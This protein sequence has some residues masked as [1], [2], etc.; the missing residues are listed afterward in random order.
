MQVLCGWVPN[1]SGCACSQARLRARI[2]SWE[3]R[4]AGSSEF[5]FRLRT[6]GGLNLVDALVDG[7]VACTIEVIDDAGM[8]RILV[9]EGDDRASNE[10]DMAWRE[11]RA[12]MDGAM[13]TVFQ[14][15][16]VDRLV[17]TGSGSEDTEALLRKFI[18]TME[19]DA[20]F[21]ARVINGR[22]SLTDHSQSP[23]YI[24]KS[25][26]M[27]NKLYFDAFRD[28]YQ[29]RVGGGRLERLC[30]EMERRVEKNE[31]A[32]EYIDQRYHRRHE[33]WALWISITAAFLSAAAL[34][35][36]V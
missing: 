6:V 27:A 15:T 1:L 24:T 13:F 17:D 33:T 9:D 28:F 21:S 32:V 3:G 5:D 20:Q 30:E 12:M 25:R 31:I 8:C 22:Y 34:V 36:T 19:A 29:H 4:D 14:C 11:F 35:M 10:A 16:V 7:R 23:S 2:D 26:Y 18:S